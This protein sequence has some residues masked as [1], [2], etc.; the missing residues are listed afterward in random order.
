MNQFKIKDKELFFKEGK[1]SFPF[2]GKVEEHL[3]IDDVMIVVFRTE[4][5]PEVPD[6]IIAFDSLGKEL[7]RV[8]ALPTVEDNDLSSANCFYNVV[9]DPNKGLLAYHSKGIFYKLNKYN[10]SLISIP[11]QR[12]W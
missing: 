2:D 1:I 9:L 10:G 6:N 11:N 5:N 3:F 4:K 7:W 12:P 8:E